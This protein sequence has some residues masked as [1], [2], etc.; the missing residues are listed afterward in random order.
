MV[1]K[2]EKEER[3]VHYGQLAEKKHPG[4]LNLH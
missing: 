1:G 3:K 2:K 4:L